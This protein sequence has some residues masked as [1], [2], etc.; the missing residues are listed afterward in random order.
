MRVVVEMP[1]FELGMDRTALIES[2]RVMALKPGSAAERAGARNGDVVV[3]TGVY[4][5][6]VT[7]PVRL[8]I[9]GGK[10]VEYLPLGS[11]RQIPQYQCP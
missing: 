8:T 4:W 5:N 2:Q 1:E 3:G 11:T 9:K 7:K 10:K 6:D